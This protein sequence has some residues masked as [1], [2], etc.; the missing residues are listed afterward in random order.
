VARDLYGNGLTDPQ[1]Y[2]EIYERDLIVELVER[3]IE[4]DHREEI[5]EAFKM[6]RQ[7]YTWD[8]IAT[9]LRDPKPEALKKRFWRWIKQN[10]PKKLRRRPLHP[11][12]HMP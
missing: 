4:K 1:S 8:E 7:G 9:Q 12:K 10:F 11:G 3:R 6:L 2:E 5:R